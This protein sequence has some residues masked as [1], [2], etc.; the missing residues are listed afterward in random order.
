[1][2]NE[3]KHIPTVKYPNAVAA[4]LRVLLDLSVAEYIQDNSIENTNNRSLKEKLKEINKN[5]NNKHIDQFLNPKNETSLDSLNM[6]IHDIKNINISINFL[7]NFFN[8]LVP[9]IK[10]LINIEEE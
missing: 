1:M 4:L 8:K 6:Y 7:N 10:D 3:L 9:I 5:L 2:F